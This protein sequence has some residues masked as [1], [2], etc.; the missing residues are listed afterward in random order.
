MV[1]VAVTSL[2]DVTIKNWDELYDN[3]WKCEHERENERDQWSSLLSL[4]IGA[5]LIPKYKEKYE[6]SQERMREVATR[7]QN[8]GL[9]L[10][11]HY[12]DTV[13]PQIEYALDAALNM[14]LPS[15]DLDCDMTSSENALAKAESFG[16]AA[17]RRY[18][19]CDEFGCDNQLQAYAAMGA[20]DNAYARKQFD[21]RRYERRLQIK[22][23]AVQ[24]AHQRTQQSPDA[25]TNLLDSAGQIYSGIFQNAQ[26]NLTG[27]VASFGSGLGGI[28]GLFGS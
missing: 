7:Q 12:L 28:G 16:S 21:T 25:F 19:A 2:P 11:D 26:T 3:I 27:A 18:G 13:A 6:K 14:D 20:V 9:L 17:L 10:K 4:A 22:R 1:A 8:I 24:A 15:T 5:W 23:Q